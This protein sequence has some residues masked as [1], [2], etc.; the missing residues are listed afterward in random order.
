MDADEVRRVEREQDEAMRVRRDNE[1]TL[2]AQDG[3]SSGKAG[4]GRQGRGASAGG[5]SRSSH[6]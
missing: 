1:R 5:R 6:I 2:Y 4:Y 3:L